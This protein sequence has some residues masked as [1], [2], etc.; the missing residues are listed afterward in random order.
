MNFLLPII[1]SCTLQFVE[2]VLVKVTTW[3]ARLQQLK[4]KKNIF[5]WDAQIV[6]NI[7]KFNNNK[8][9]CNMPKY[10][11]GEVM[12]SRF[13]IQGLIRSKGHFDFQKNKILQGVIWGNL[14][15]C[16][17]IELFQSSKE[18]KFHHVENPNSKC[19]F[20][21]LKISKIKLHMNKIWMSKVHQVW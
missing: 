14:R 19:K 7:L 21:A 2:I 9:V 13:D 1:R 12:Q 17:S 8:V 18:T 5:W 20:I 4:G 3:I 15:T 10:K 6:V 11:N 16:Y